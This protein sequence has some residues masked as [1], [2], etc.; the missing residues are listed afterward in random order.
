ML[1]LPFVCAAKQS[2][3]ALALSLS[4]RA[5]PTPT[6]MLMYL[7]CQQPTRIH[8]ERHSDAM[9][10]DGARLAPMRSRGMSIFAHRDSRA[11]TAFPFASLFYL[12]FSD[13]YRSDATYQL[14][15]SQLIFP[16]FPALFLQSASA[17][18]LPRKRSSQPEPALLCK[19]PDLSS[20]HVYFIL[21]L[22]IVELASFSLGTNISCNTAP[23]HVLTSKSL[24]SPLTAWHGM[25]W[26]W[27]K[28]IIP[29]VPFRPVN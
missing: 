27:Q 8:D 10:C 13:T 3:H 1:L 4:L 25:A 12:L 28:S 26:V 5:M 15:P 16:H 7:I 24:R 23:F 21:Q 17:N 6:L 22:L 9:R 18:S 20:H 14:P 19:Q 11:T 29:I 2:S